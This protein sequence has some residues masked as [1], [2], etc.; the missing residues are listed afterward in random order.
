MGKKE[1]SKKELK[2]KKDSLEQILDN[3]QLLNN[4]PTVHKSRNTTSEKVKE[5]VSTTLFLGELALG[6][7]ACDPRF[8]QGLTYF[9][10]ANGLDQEI[11]HV[12]ISGG[13][14]PMI[15]TYYGVQMAR[16]MV[17]LGN[18]WDQKI[19]DRALLA[20]KEDISDEDKDF[21]QKWV[22]H[23]ITN[24]SQAVDYTRTVMA[25]LTSLLNDGTVW[26]YL[27]GEED[28]KNIE[29]LLEIN[30]NKYIDSQKALEEDNKKKETLEQQLKQLQAKA[31]Q[32]DA[33]S[34]LLRAVRQ[35]IHQDHDR[36]R[37]N[38][39]LTSFVKEKAKDI[40]ALE[41]PEKFKKYLSSVKSRKAASARVEKLDKQLKKVREDSREKERELKD[42]LNAL[43][44]RK[45]Q[46][47]ASQFHHLNKQQ[48][49]KTF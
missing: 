36:D 8:Y 48:K 7:K 15:P 49:T 1:D 29:M 6:T 39:Y 13:L 30:I 12:V 41:D 32:Y 42:T 10:E 22:A 28:N 26:H 38:E 18:N 40:D 37:V 14:L 19:N 20:L 4:D 17:F 21:I 33:Q 16:E 46:E 35:G 47:E 2:P 24:T 5:G 11:G 25:P 23:K 9:L 31:T 43:N 34:Q 45:R 44:A 3:D 27:H